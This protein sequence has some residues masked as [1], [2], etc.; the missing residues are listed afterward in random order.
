MIGLKYISIN[1]NIKTKDITSRN[2]AFFKPDL[3]VITG[4]YFLPNLEKD[5]AKTII[6]IINNNIPK[7]NDKI[8]WVSK[9]LSDSIPLKPGTMNITIKTMLINAIIIPKIAEDLWEYPKIRFERTRKDKNI[10]M[11]PIINIPITYP[12]SVLSMEYNVS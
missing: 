12:R 6:V 10:S 3:V 1:K 5:S 4:R 8:K 7:I 2:L 11:I 9:I